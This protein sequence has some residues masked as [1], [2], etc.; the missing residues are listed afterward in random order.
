MSQFNQNIEQQAPAS[1]PPSLFAPQATAALR[2]STKTVLPPS[3]SFLRSHILTD[4]DR[5][6]FPA[7]TLPKNS[8]SMKS[9]L[10]ISHVSHEHSP[11]KVFFGKP[12]LANIAKP[13]K[14]VSKIYFE[15]SSA[16]FKQTNNFLSPLS[17][18]AVWYL[19]VCLCVPVTFVYVFCYLYS[20]HS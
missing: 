9:S 17:S 1:Q 4:Y 14:S 8:P 15:Y 18:A 19:F 11:L 7:K 3:S 2:V 16:N 12:I 13:A 5:I 10:K 20:V 6:K